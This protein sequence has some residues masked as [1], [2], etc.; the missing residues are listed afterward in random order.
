MR[1]RCRTA[2]HLATNCLTMA[3]LA[4]HTQPPAIGAPSK[5]NCFPPCQQARK[6][7][8][9]NRS[10]ATRTHLASSLYHARERQRAACPNCY[11][12]CDDIQRVVRRRCSLTR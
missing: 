11:L 3:V 1:P 4:S 10:K 7:V 9:S 5:I 12:Q 6:A 8:P 2:A